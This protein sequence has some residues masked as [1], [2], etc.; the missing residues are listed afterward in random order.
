MGISFITNVPR[1]NFEAPC[2]GYLEDEGPTK[3]T[4]IRP[5]DFGGTVD[6]AADPPGPPRPAGPSMVPGDG[7]TPRGR[8]LR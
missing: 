5:N 6:R 3:P 2:G 7:V 1:W 8:S 4:G